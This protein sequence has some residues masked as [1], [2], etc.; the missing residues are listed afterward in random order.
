LPDGLLVD[1]LHATGKT[2]C[3]TV[4]VPLGLFD[5]EKWIPFGALA[6][7]VLLDWEV[8]ERGA[9]PLERPAVKLAVSEQGPIDADGQQ[10]LWTFFMRNVFLGE[11]R[12]GVIDLPVLV[13]TEARR[14]PGSRDV[15]YGP[16]LF[17]PEGWLIAFR[18]Y[19]VEAIDP[20]EVAPMPEEE[21]PAF[22]AWY[23]RNGFKPATIDLAWQVPHR[24]AE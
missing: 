3:A 12:S 22:V 6:V 16:L 15:V 19:R 20:S 13:H 4:R 9:D 5:H 23:Q 10:R 7:R 11:A 17:I 8:L 1:T 14:I 24:G 2:G 21:G 18:N